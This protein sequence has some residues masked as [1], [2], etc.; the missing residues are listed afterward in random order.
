M[1]YLHA[2][3]HSLFPRAHTRWYHCSHYFHQPL[4]RPV[5]HARKPSCL[6]SPFMLPAVGP[7]LPLKS[8][9]A[10]TRVLGRLRPDPPPRGGRGAARKVGPQ[11]R[12][13][14]SLLGSERTLRSGGR[15]GHGRECSQG[16]KWSVGSRPQ[17]LVCLE[18]GGPKTEG[19]L[20]EEQREPGQTNPCSGGV[21]FPFLSLYG[22]CGRDSS[23]VT[24]GGNEGWAWVAQPLT[25]DLGWGHDLTG[26]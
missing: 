1:K 3:F 15:E 9:P 25:L 14:S 13:R 23:A 21:F 6:Y 2:W 24:A 22:L 20:G 17:G 11:T 26:S 5:L 4:P 12:L 16:R 19:Q 18:W 8:C 10:R 7:A